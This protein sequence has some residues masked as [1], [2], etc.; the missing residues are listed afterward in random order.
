MVVREPFVVDTLL[1]LMVWNGNWVVCGAV[2][3]LCFVYN[4]VG[5]GA[6]RWCDAI[7]PLRE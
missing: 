1:P 3:V 5:R 2:V 7:C 4:V 6:V